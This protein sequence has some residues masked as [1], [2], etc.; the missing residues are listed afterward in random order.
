MTREKKIEGKY[1]Y[2]TDVKLQSQ[3]RK[4]HEWGIKIFKQKMTKNFL[5]GNINLQIPQKAANYKPK[6]N[7]SWIYQIQTVENLS[8]TISKAAREKNHI[9][10]KR[11]V[12]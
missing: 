9:T 2:L 10:Y 12:I 11:T 4:E 6:E 1:A 8:E 7:Q 3:R 5:F